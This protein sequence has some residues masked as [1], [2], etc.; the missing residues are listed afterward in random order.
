MVDIE[1]FWKRCRFEAGVERGEIGV[2]A[3]VIKC[4]LCVNVCV[5]SFYSRYKWFYVVVLIKVK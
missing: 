4:H 3:N 2:Y 5:V 1:H